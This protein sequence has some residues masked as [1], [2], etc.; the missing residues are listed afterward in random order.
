MTAQLS[1]GRNSLGPCACVYV[2]M[3]GEERVGK[4]DWE[5]AKREAILFITI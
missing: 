5:G 2:Q 4:G 1:C 3:A